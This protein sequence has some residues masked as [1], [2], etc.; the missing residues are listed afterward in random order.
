M[1]ADHRLEQII[2]G[3]GVI[4]IP[5]Q[6][7]LRDAVRLPPVSERRPGSVDGQQLPWQQAVDVTVEASVSAGGN[8]RQEPGDP[9]LVDLAL[10]VRQ[11]EQAKGRLANANSR[12]EAW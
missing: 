5:A 4:L 12:A 6:P 1:P 3:G 2:E 11:R 9:V 8:P 10:D 7:D